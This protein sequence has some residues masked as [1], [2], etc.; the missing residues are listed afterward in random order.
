[1]LL[2]ERVFLVLEGAYVT[3]ALEGDE[4]VFDRARDL[5]SVLVTAEVASVSQGSR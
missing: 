3:G 1:M 4:S 5:M 2:A